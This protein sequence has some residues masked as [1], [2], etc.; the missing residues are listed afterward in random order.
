MP[1]SVG[2]TAQLA[3]GRLPCDGFEGQVLGWNFQ[4]RR[5]LIVLGPGGFLTRGSREGTLP[6]F[7]FKRWGRLWDGSPLRCGFETGFRSDLLLLQTWCVLASCGACLILGL[8]RIVDAGLPWY[9][10]MQKNILNVSS[11]VCT[12]SPKG[13]TDTWGNTCS[14]KKVRSKPMIN[15]PYGRQIPWSTNAKPIGNKPDAQQ[16][17]C[18]T[19][20]ESPTGKRYVHQTQ[21][22][23]KANFRQGRCS[24]KT[25]TNREKTLFGK[26]CVQ[27]AYGAT[28]E[29][30]VEFGNMWE[31]LGASGKNW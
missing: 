10:H 16:T 17:H 25:K 14:K 29:H 22:Q 13:P 5:V 11:T 31:H 7:P 15:K 24:T 26:A 4:G 12:C 3:E 30:L 6:G 19:T 18:S 9:P 20:S 2:A 23:P 27:G 28:G 8:F 1:F 21:S